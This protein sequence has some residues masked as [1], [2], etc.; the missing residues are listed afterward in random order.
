MKK[1]K[2]PFE[3]AGEVFTKD[4]V[5]LEHNP[6]FINKILSFQPITVLMA[7][8][9]NK[10]LPKLPIWAVNGIYNNS[11]KRRRS[12]PYIYYPK[13]AKI[14]KDRRLLRKRIS[15]AFNTGDKHSDQ[16]IE[17]LKMLGETPEDYFGMKLKR[18]KKQQKTGN[19]SGLHY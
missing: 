15:S 6:F 12:S 5:E 10:L 13:S 11:I 8:E 14:K 1:N 9:V 17:L 16:I 3:I 2:S 4:K 18:K 7:I 19:V